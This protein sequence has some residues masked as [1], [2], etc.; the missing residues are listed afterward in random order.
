MHPRRLH[1]LRHAKSSWK[2]PIQSDHDRPLSSRGERTLDVIRGHV[3]EH[4]I[5]P[6]VILCST[7]RRAVATAA[8]IGLTAPVVHEPALYSATAD[9][10]LA[11]LRR[12]DPAVH[13]VLLVGH[14]PALQMLILRLADCRHADHPEL[15]DDVRI[16]LP[17][18]AFASFDVGCDWE[19]LHDGAAQLA[20]LMCPRALQY[21]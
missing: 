7:A 2:E 13:E 21:L 19:H 8:G 9:D 17:T 3:V 16:K 5:A 4:D 15:L 14:N 20:T 10:L 18:G 6:D 1:L 11:R 12:V